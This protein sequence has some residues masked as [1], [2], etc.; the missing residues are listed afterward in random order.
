[1]EKFVESEVELNKLKYTEHLNLKTK[2][3][4]PFQ[5]RSTVLGYILFRLRS[6]CAFYKH[7]ILS[8]KP[9]LVFK[10]V[11][12]HL[13]IRRLVLSDVEKQSPVQ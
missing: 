4:W 5:G 9:G 6:I 8:F 11:D 1:M 13:E 7:A 3:K 10:T 2:L 12:K